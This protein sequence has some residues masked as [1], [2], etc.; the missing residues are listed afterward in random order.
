MDFNTVNLECIT[1]NR[2]SITSN[3]KYISEAKYE[4]EGNFPEDIEILS[5]HLLAKSPIMS[6]DRKCY[7]TVRFNRTNRDFFKF[8]TGLEE[9]SKSAIL[10]NT[11]SWFHKD[12]P[13]DVIDDYHNQFVKISSHED[14]SIKVQI[15]F[16]KD[17][18]EVEIPV[19]TDKGVA[20]NQ[21][22]IFEGTVLRLQMRYM[23]IKFYKQQFASEWFATKIVVYDD[24]DQDENEEDF[25]FRDNEDM[26]SLYSDQAPVS[27]QAQDDPTHDSNIE[28]SVTKVD[29]DGPST[30]PEPL[31]QDE[32]SSTVATAT[33]TASTTRTEA[34]TEDNLDQTH[35]DGTTS[36]QLA[37]T[38]ALDVKVNMVSG[39][40]SVTGSETPGKNDDSSST[41]S[42]TEPGE[43]NSRHQLI[44]EELISQELPPAS[45]NPNQKPAIPPPPP[46]PPPRP[47]VSEK[48]TEQEPIPTPASIRSHRS[49]HSR[50][51][52]PKRR[53]IKMPNGKYKFLN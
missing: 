1:Y 41:D 29:F 21:N 45:I 31:A 32:T 53:R 11:M 33:S 43:S 30:E 9:H 39:A 7:L 17:T 19:T 13:I 40:S 27:V 10:E 4:V 20:I 2:P 37:V 18:N 46:L 6:T 36:E 44:P 22:A 14:P 51:I 50:L 34:G 8:L 47:P 12:M 3:R 24:Y 15:P 49:R 26:M 48:M 23:G 35:D 38:S 42:V 25:D 52:R 5:P 28:I 16:N